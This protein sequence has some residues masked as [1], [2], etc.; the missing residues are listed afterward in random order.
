M[1][2]LPTVIENLEKSRNFTDALQVLEKS[3]NC[4]NL[5]HRYLKVAMGLR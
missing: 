3:R 2:R 1:Y 5:D 4:V